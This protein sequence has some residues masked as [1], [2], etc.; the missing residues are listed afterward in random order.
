EPW[1]PWRIAQAFIAAGCPPEA[2]S[3]YPTSHEGSQAI[4]EYAGR[5]LL[6]GDRKTVDRYRGNPRVEV[7]GPGYSKVLIGEDEI[8]QW[9]DHLDVLVRSVLDNGGRSC[10]NA[11]TIIVPRHAD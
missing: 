8:D 10:I 3:F 2:L 9:E 7:H 6:F 1:T 11:S 5:A 4:L